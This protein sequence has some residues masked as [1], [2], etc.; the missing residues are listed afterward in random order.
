MARRV[1]GDNGSSGKSNGVCRQFRGLYVAHRR[2]EEIMSQV[3]GRGGYRHQDLPGP[4]AKLLGRSD[5]NTIFNVIEACLVRLVS[6]SIVPSSSA[7][8]PSP[9]RPGKD[10]PT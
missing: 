6:E 9:G 2:C 4:L 5:C 10:R 8:S 1:R 3:P 7:D